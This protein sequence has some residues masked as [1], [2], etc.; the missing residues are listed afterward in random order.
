MVLDLAACDCR[1]LHLDPLHFQL[2]RLGHWLAL[3]TP[4]TYEVVRN[5]IEGLKNP[6]VIRDKKA[7]AVLPIR[8][9]GVKEA[10]QKAIANTT[11]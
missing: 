1:P 8:P 7:L 5:L 10:L 3:V 9:M 11:E 6:A 4:A 2:E